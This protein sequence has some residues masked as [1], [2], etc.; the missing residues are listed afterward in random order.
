[1][2]SHRILVVDDDSLVRHMIADALEAQGY[3]VATA[4]ESFGALQCLER[5]RPDAVVC[6]VRMPGLD[7]AALRR[8][9]RRGEQRLPFLLISGDS[10]TGDHLDDASDA[11]TAFL[12]KPFTPDELT[13]RL[14]QL[15]D[16]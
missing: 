13:T 3:Q 11:R 14:R 8:L 15:L 7:G 12:A 10:T 2:T 4:S 6:D 1:V 5:E 16:E 9:L